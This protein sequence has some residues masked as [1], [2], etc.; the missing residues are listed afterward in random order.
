MLGQGSGRNSGYPNAS[1]G[2]V[3]RKLLAIGRGGICGV[4]A[5]QMLVSAPQS[6]AAKSAKSRSAIRAAV[7]HANHCVGS[8]MASEQPHHPHINRAHSHHRRRSRHRR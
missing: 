5:L 3:R 8:S 6:G 7:H 1:Q 2:K 4:L